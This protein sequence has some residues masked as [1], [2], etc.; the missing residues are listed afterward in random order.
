MKVRAVIL[1]WAGTTIDFG[2]RAPAAVFVEVFRRRG[3][4][5]R[6]AEARGPMGLAKRDH[7]AAITALPRVNEC[8]RALHGQSPDDAAIEAMY[9]DFLPLQK[10][11]LANH[12]DVI[13]GA[14]DALDE[15]R[16]QGIAIGSTTGYTR[17]LMEVVMPLAERNGYR[18]D[19]TVC[20]DDVRAGR[21]APWMNFRAAELLAVYPMNSV[22]VVDDTLVGIDAGL[23][24]G[25]WTVAVVESGNAFGLSPEQLASLSPSE[26]S[27]RWETA[28]SEFR[29][30]GAHFVIPSV[31]ALPDVVRQIQSR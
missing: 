5:I 1:D 22:I 30:R 15:C 28:E 27:E 19:A 2:S 4:E 7:I 20:S 23:H 16:R 11:T 9:R 8:W 24:A 29:A 26:R 12:V 6:I 31:A 14:I 13:P 10:A 18:P 25:C 3:V 21:P 17:E